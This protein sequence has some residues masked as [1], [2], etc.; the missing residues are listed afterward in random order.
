MNMLS[1]LVDLLA[2]YV[3]DTIPVPESEIRQLAK[4]QGIS[5]R[6]DHLQFLMRYGCDH[7]NRPHI[8]KWYGGDFDFFSLKGLY[9]D[10][11]FE[12]EL[13][14]GANYFGSDFVGE[15]FC[16]DHES[17]GIFV[18][19]EDERYGLV[20]ETL[21]GFLLRCLVSVYDEVAFR[22]IEVSLK[23]G[24]EKID[25][26]RSAN[27]DRKIDGATGFMIEYKEI[28]APTVIAEYYFVDQQLIAVY[29][30]TG[31]MV[32]MSGGILENLKQ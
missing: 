4:D 26:F 32:T 24:R 15:T 27:E 16:I 6:D 11:R 9:L 19:D 28:D 29:P 14:I 12:V 18:F 17:G 10:K 13:P 23:S 20:H 22:N 2:V 31:S 3:K 8:F 25:E 21:N 1:E 7:G 30:T 5:F